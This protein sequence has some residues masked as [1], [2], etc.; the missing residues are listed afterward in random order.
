MFKKWRQA[1]RMKMALEFC[2]KTQQRYRYSIYGT[3][4]GATEG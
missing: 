1:K 3:N 2:R 4:H